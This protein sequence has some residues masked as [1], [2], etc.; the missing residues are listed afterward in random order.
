M[1]VWA[2]AALALWSVP[3]FIVGALGLGLPPF[4]AFG[5]GA[6]AAVL[7][8]VAIAPWLASVLSPVRSSHV[9][10]RVGLLITT[11]TAIARIASLSIF[12]A[13]VSQAAHSLRPED[14]FRTRHSCVSSYAEAARL[15]AEGGHNIYD[16]HLYQPRQIGA[17]NV[18]PYHYPPPFLLLPRAIH[19]VSADFFHFRSI[20]FAFQMLVLGG[21]IVLTSVWIGGSAGSMA[22]AG[23]VLLLALPGVLFGFQQGNFQVTA[24]PIALIAVVL[25][26][27]R[28]TWAGALMLAYA[29]MAKIFPGILIVYLAAARQWGTLAR[30]AVCGGLLMALTLAT[31]GTRP[32]IDFVTH[33]VPEI[34]S[35]AAFPQTELPQAVPVNWTAYGLT[36]RLRNL[37]V[38]ALD[39]RTG[40]RIASVY[41]VLIIALAALAGWRADRG[42]RRTPNK[43]QGTRSESEDRIRLLQVTLALVALASFRSPFAGAPY[44]SMSTLWL[45]TFVAAGEPTIRR[46][47]IWL[48]A[49]VAIGTAI[50]ALPSPAHAQTTFT[51]VASGL[52]FLSNV[53]IGVWAVWRGAISS[54]RVASAPAALPALARS[55]R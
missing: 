40:L 10:V 20:W 28:Q 41:G 14:P 42:K 37:G 23:G 11:A 29:A 15:Q 16:V 48:V 49:M 50:W 13:D 47:A 51:L 46:A 19:T 18:D 9:L 24:A 54:A 52:L 36:V 26:S 44:G 7:A 22:L 43:E 30:V 2:S 45:M 21:A 55:P 32:T 33:A 39:Q 6:A 38:T 12:M 4:A 35:A 27:G 53:A 31:Q 25:I 34:T 5:V 1:R 3:V 17:L 8:G